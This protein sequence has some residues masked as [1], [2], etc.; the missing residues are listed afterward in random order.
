MHRSYT[1]SIL[2][3]PCSVFKWLWILIHVLNP[4][5]LN[6]DLLCLSKIQNQLRINKLTNSTVF[7]ALHFHA[8]AD[9]KPARNWLSIL[10]PDLL[11][12]KS[13][14][15]FFQSLHWHYRPTKA[16]SIC[17]LHGGWSCHCAQIIF[18]NCFKKNVIIRLFGKAHTY[19]CISI[20]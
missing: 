17:S 8:V 14:W 4:L 1:H 15:I 5:L 16:P 12:N 19:R 9:C 3:S 13:T 18:A 7:S 10:S 2:C 6:A 20:N 11:V